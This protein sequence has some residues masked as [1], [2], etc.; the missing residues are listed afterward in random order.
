AQ[1]V[2]LFSVAVLIHFVLLSSA[3]YNWIDGPYAAPAAMAEA[4]PPSR[5]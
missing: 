1:G 4:L 5:Q 2:F 3:K